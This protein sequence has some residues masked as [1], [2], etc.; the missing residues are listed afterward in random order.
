MTRHR[1]EPAETHDG[2]DRS[3]GAGA[4]GQRGDV[5]VGGHASDGD[6]ADDREHLCLECAA[7]REGVIGHRTLGHLQ[8]G[9]GY[10][11]GVVFH[12]SWMTPV[13][14]SFVAKTIWPVWAVKWS[15]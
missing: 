14:M 6:P 15:N 4:P 2:A 7:W 12:T 11:I 5:A 13:W 10:V 8:G 3:P 1:W 9:S